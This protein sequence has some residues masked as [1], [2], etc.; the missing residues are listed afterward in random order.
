MRYKEGDILKFYSN[1]YIIMWV[2]HFTKEYGIQTKDGLYLNFYE[3]E[4]P[5]ENIRLVNITYKDNRL[6]QELNNG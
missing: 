1:I 5:D 4:L 3:D 2:C 6:Y